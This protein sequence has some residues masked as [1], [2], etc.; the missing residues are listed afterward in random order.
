MSYL[1]DYKNAEQS[2]G[3]CFE[4]TPAQIN[5]L[6]NG[7]SIDQLEPVPVSRETLQK[8]AQQNNSLSR[9]MSILY[10]CVHTN[11]LLTSADVYKLAIDAEVQGVITANQADLL[12]IRAVVVAETHNRNQ[13][14]ESI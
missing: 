7:A 6:N 12:I 5:Q 8:R 2:S 3:E 9:A 10:K 13:Q 11:D 4:Y 1:T 14:Q